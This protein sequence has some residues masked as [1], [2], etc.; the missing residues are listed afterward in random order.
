MNS[1]SA[2]HT[3]ITIRSTFAFRLHRN[4][5][6][7]AR[8]TSSCSIT[9]FLR[10]TTTLEV[11]F[12]LRF[13]NSSLLIFCL[14]LEVLM[15]S[16][17]ASSGL[18]NAVSVASLYCPYDQDRFDKFPYRYGEVECQQSKV[19]HVWRRQSDLNLIWNAPHS[20]LAGLRSRPPQT[21]RRSS[22]Q[23]TQNPPSALLRR[24]RRRSA[25]TFIL[26]ITVHTRFFRIHIKLR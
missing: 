20:V 17:V 3:P 13:T 26:G 6:S 21:R 10:G 14:S 2:M 16:L 9:Q 25:D 23:I 18:G 1:N 11:V 22:F 8:T 12:G 24:H 19:Q 4:L 7:G 5:F 15:A